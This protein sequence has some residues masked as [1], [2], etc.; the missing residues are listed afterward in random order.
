MSSS[1]SKKVVRYI[2]NNCATAHMKWSGKCSGCEQWNT[3]VAESISKDDV[4]LYKINGDI[5][6]YELDAKVEQVNRIEIGISEFDRVIG[7]GIVP[8]AAILLGGEPG[9]GK[10]TLVLQILSKLRS[11]GM[12]VLYLSAEESLQQIQLRAI[13]LKVVE[14][15]I[16]VS[17]LTSLQE[18]KR[19]ID[20][21]KDVGFVV[22][23][24]IQTIYDEAIE[25]APGSVNQ[26]RSCSFELIRMAKQKG[27]ALL[28]IGHVN[29]DGAIA[30]PK[31]L[32]HMV[33]T[34]L[35]FEGD[36]GVQ[37]RIVRA[38]KNRFGPANEIAVFEMSKN[39]LEEVSNPSKYF[40]PVTSE[41]ASGSCIFVSMEGS[42]PLL[43]EVQAL[44]VPSYL[45]SPRRSVV[46]WDANR[47]AMLIAVLNARLNINILDK[48]VYLNM[49]GGLKVSEPAADLAVIAALI[50]AARN[51]T[52]D[53][54]T[55]FFGEVG[56]SGEVRSVVHIESRL[57]EAKKLGFK[58]AII[59][60]NVEI[61]NDSGLELVKI[62]HIK[63]LLKI[64]G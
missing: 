14:D 25:S 31:V 12:D 38:I 22:I 23:D 46:G 7:G 9:I 58:R 10:S 18:I 64:I 54:E 26:V 20:T 56:L 13:R 59:P 2:C 57:M 52:L 28:I 43:L 33:D 11:L 6:I 29:K 60:M 24:S 19:A 36:N 5:S 34:V 16:K 4:K 21:V 15:G 50:S 42:R 47:L 3:L 37:Y 48:E 32:E 1:S 35:Y 40:L 53:R 51:I 30:G 39:G 44:C 61:S 62:E 41:N 27:F 17:C 8:G 45:A 63:N 55:V 49:V